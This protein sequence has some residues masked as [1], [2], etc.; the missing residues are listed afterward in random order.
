MDKNELHKLIC[1][2]QGINSYTN[3]Q[4]MDLMNEALQHAILHYLKH[5]DSNYL[6]QIVNA[7]DKK[8]KESLIIEL[9]SILGLNY[10]YK[11]MSFKRIKNQKPDID[12]NEINNYRP[13][14]RYSLSLKDDYVEVSGKLSSKDLYNFIADSLTL[15]RNQFSNEQIE[16]L[17]HILLRIARKNEPTEIK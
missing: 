11:S 8:N 9:R 3:S 4:F 16:E 10:S 17:S 1:I 12:E 5:G 13:I 14:N 2:A 6:N 15:Y 7:L